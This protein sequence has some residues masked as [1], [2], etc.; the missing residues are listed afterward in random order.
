MRWVR[1][2]A[3]ARNTA[4]SAMFSHAA[5]WCSPTHA[6]SKPSRS[7]HS[8]SSRSRRNVI[9]GLSPSGWYGARNTPKSIAGR[10]HT[11]DVERTIRTSRQA[12][13][14]PGTG[15]SSVEPCRPPVSS[16]WPPATA[17]TCRRSSTRAPTA[18]CRPPSSPSCRTRPTPAPWCG[19]APPG[20]PAVH[21]GR[22]PGEARADYDARLADVVAGFG[23]DLVVLAG[24]MRI[25][26][27]SFLGWFPDRVVNLHPALPGELA[28]HPR[29]RAG[30]G[31]GAGRRR[32]PRPA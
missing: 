20:V 30:V 25:L 14:G 7:H 18:A 10:W 29:H 28:R 11:A 13:V 19:P 24:W 12:S 2:P 8:M 4:G 27:M 21:V 23:P 15:A 3:A 17:R 22:N 6:S 9:S 1:W 5:E 32:A 31:G 26:T 16:C